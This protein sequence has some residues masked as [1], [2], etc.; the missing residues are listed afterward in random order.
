M[1][2]NEA[3]TNNESSHSIAF[4]AMS[5]SF[6]SKDPGFEDRRFNDALRPCH[7]SPRVSQV[8]SI[9]FEPAFPVL[10]V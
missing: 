6:L 1:E 10:P 5:G 4:G 8:V 3:K 2:K 9:F 7:A